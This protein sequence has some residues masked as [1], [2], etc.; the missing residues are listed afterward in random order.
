MPAAPISGAPLRSA[1]LTVTPASWAVLFGRIILA[2][3]TRN[4]LVSGRRPLGWALAAVVAAAAAEPLV[5]L[6]ARRLRRGIALVVVLVPVVAAIGL[7]TFAVVSD[8]DSQV[9]R[10]QD[11]IPDAAQDIEQSARFGEAA[12]EFEMVDKAE[13]LAKRLRRPSAQ[14]GEEAAGGASGWFLTL[15]LTVFALGYGPRFSRAALAQVRDEE[16]RVRLA[17]IVGR[18]FQRSQL[19]IDTAL[20]LAIATGIVAW[21]AFSLADLPAPTPL[22]L[23]VGV[24]SLV[25]SFGVFLATIPAVI[26]AAADASPGQAVALAVGAVIV[27]VAHRAALRRATAAT[28]RPGSAVIV[29][30][31]LIGFDLYGTGGAIVATTVA[32]FATAL[33]DSIGEEEAEGRAPARR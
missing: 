2:L 13:D 25:P 27:Q 19:Y 16:H 15:I 17:H 4:V 26:L 29:I 32:V 18:A 8:L 5:T 31:F 7:V 11:A 14:V 3:V 33:L 9:R 23:V 30:P 6:V 22:A 1:Q 10:L 24:A 12:R 28:S 20:V 21:L